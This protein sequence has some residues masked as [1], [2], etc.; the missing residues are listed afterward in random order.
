MNERKI[1][2][3]GHEGNCTS[4]VLKISKGTN[5]IQGNKISKFYRAIT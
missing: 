5:R 1:T 4:Y 3:K 2:V